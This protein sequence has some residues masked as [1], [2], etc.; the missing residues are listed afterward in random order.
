[1]EANLL[2]RLQNFAARTVLHQHR[3]SSAGAARE[4]EL[5]L[6]TLASHCKLHLA[7]HAFRGIRGSHPLYLR[8][9]FMECQA[10]HGHRTR[11]AAMGNIH[12]P[13][14]KS[15]FGK[16][17]FSYCTTG[18]WTTLPDEAHFTSSIS[19]FNSIAESLLT[20]ST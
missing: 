18:I 10:T 19:H 3:D 1:M 6:L 9:L 20:T 5:Q 17:T 4:E 11:H 8:K 15:N 12:L 2:Q 7:Q 16:K 13:L 14:L